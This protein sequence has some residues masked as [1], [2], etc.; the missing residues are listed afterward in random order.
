MQCRRFENSL[1]SGLFRI[2][3]CF[4][5]IQQSVLLS[6]SVRSE[7]VWCRRFRIRD[8]AA[9]LRFTNACKGWNQSWLVPR[10]HKNLCT[11]AGT[12][13]PTLAWRRTCKPQKPVY[14][15]KWAPAKTCTW[16]YYASVFWYGS[17]IL[18]SNA[19]AKMCT[20]R[21]FG[22]PT[23][24][25]Q[26]IL[27]TVVKTCCWVLTADLTAADS[28]GFAHFQIRICLGTKPVSSSLVFF[29]LFSLRIFAFPKKCTWFRRLVSQF[30]W[31]WCHLQN[32]C[33]VW[34]TGVLFASYPA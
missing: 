22:H 8:P 3:F 2:L 19:V 21:E 23:Q 6:L 28:E 18:Q 16:P 31:R 4:R 5:L 10:A 13:R 25:T 14:P 7:R 17:K 24:C 29:I 34:N 9:K 20:N 33:R 30:R 1:F 12:D 26:Y 15:R 32:S 11:L 27:H